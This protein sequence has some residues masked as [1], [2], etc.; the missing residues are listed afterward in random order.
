MKKPI[1]AVIDTSVILAGLMSPSGA[2]YAILEHY[3]AKKS[4]V[5]MLSQQLYNEYLLKIAL[6]LPEIQKRAIKNGGN[7]TPETIDEILA[8]IVK[9]SA[10]L[11]VASVLALTDDENDDHIATM[12][13]E[14]GADYLVTLDK[15]FDVMKERDYTVSIIRP[16]EFIHILRLST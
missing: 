3:L 6:K 7:M 12:A 14:Y 4:F 2:S 8:Y 13:I 16:S 9:T 10:W 5:W 15:D 11:D 1:F